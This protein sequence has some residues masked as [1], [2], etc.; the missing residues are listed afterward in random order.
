[1]KKIILAIM[2]FSLIFAASGIVLA[3]ELEKIPSPDQIKYFKMIKKEGNALFGV[4]IKTASS[5]PNMERKAEYPNAMNNRASST[6]VRSNAS[7]S[8]LEK[9][10]SPKEI[11][12]FEKIKKIGTALWG[13]RKDGATKPAEARPVIVKPIAV[14]CVKDAIDKKDNAV[15]T[16]ISS[17]SQ[18]LM[19]AIDVR[20]T[21]QKAALD[22]TTGAEQFEANK[23]CVK[24]FQQSAKNSNEA[25]K[26]AR[27][28]AW[29][30]YKADLKICSEL[31]KN[32]LATTTSAA[33]S[34]AE[35]LEI[36]LNDGDEN[37]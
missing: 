2:V 15:K 17:S 14:Q 12:L 13:I 8:V 18:V 28:E 3:Q 33:A 21:C 29:K 20:N 11:N 34:S 5:T 36:M 6:N 31:Q 25:M 23:L 10:S 9:I 16:G 24:N 19:S 7:E 4:R 30:N 37:N 22:K 26:N 1:M 27:N 32:S 35:S